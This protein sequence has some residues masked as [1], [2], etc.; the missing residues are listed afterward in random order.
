VANHCVVL[1]LTPSACAALDIDPNPDLNRITSNR[2]SHNG[3]GPDPSV[4]PAFAVDLAWDTPGAGNC[5]SRH[6][7]GTTLPS[8][9][10]ACR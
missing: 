1:G 6:L 7:A 4:P 3:S 10:P 9:L 8:S 2:V 5:W